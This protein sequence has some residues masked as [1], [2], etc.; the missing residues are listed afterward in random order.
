[1]NFIHLLGFKVSP[2]DSAML[3]F[4]SKYCNQG[5]HELQS[6]TLDKAAR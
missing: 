2:T 3:V 4:P 6:T 1:M 5:P